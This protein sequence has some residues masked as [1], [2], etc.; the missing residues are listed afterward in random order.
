MI[1]VLSPLSLDLDAAS[2]LIPDDDDEELVDLAKSRRKERLENDKKVGKTFVSEGD[3]NSTTISKV[4]NAVNRLAK[5]GLSL[6]AGDLKSLASSARWNS[7][8]RA[9]RTY[10]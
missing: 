6:E 7:F 4:Q 2:A 5:D 8:V 9:T 3:Y 1:I 10:V